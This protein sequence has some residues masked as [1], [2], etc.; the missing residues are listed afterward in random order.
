MI[1]HHENQFDQDFG[2]SSWAC[3]PA[4]VVPQAELK[5]SP[6]PLDNKRVLVL[7]DDPTQQLLLVQQLRKLGLSVVTAGTIGEAKQRLQENTIQ[8]AILDVQ[9][10]DG[11][12]FDFCEQLDSDSAYAGLPMII[13]SS[14]TSAEVVR[15]TRASGGQFFLCKPYDPNVL[16]TIIERALA[17]V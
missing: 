14:M 7:E 9:L 16:L 5:S 3:Q 6:T 10:P 4:I 15:R 1:P 8:L 12:G 2:W 17:D 13:L 11:S